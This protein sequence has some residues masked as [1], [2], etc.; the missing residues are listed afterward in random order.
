MGLDFDIARHLM[1][2]T[3]IRANYSIDG[4]RNSDAIQSV[5]EGNA[6]QVFAE[7]ANLAIGVQVGLHYTFNLT[8]AFARREAA[9][10]E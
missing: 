9:A 8:R 6:E 5:I 2:S 1:I 4:F 7:K 10:A 3:Q